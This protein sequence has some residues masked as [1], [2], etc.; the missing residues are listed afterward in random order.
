MHEMSLCESILHIMEDQAEAR[1]FERVKSVRLEIGGFSGVDVEAL[2][3]QS[4]ALGENP[5]AQQPGP[6]C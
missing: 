4:R 6:G 2:R 3:A 1:A 5:A